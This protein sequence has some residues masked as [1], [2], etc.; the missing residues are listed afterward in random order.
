M[1]RTWKWVLGVAAALIVA[2]VLVVVI[3]TA[4]FLGAGGSVDAEIARIKAEG[5]PTTAADL[6]GKPIPDSENAA[7]TYQKALKLLPRPS[8]ERDSKTLDRFLDPKERSSDPPLWA[9]AKEIVQRYSGALPIAREAATKPKCRFAV[10]WRDPLNAEFPHYRRLRFLTRLAG[11]KAVLEARAGDS[12]GA[13]ES[14]ELAYGMNAALRDEPGLIAVLVRYAMIRCASQSLA[15]TARYGAIDGADAIRLARALSQIQ[16][17]GSMAKAYQGERAEGIV[18]FGQQRSGWGSDA[19]SA[20]VR[21]FYNAFPGSLWLDSDEAYYLGEMAR[22]IKGANLPYRVMKPHFR[23]VDPPRYALISGIL[24]S[25]HL[26]ATAARDRAIASL[27]GDQLFLGLV[28]YRDRFGSYPAS[29]A[30]LKK[31]NWQL[32]EDPFSGKPFVYHRKGSGFVL[33]SIGDDLKD[34]GGVEPNGNKPG[35]IVWKLDR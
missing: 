3:L 16:L 2:G 33:Y 26:R 17:M 6:A 4:R 34:N 20:R 11:T 30:D 15:D 8:D 5:G 31:V 1:S 7:V 35:D 14:V 24:I 32:P 25:T 28:A 23:A 19:D 21:G 18:I 9:Q 13:I 22:Q 29:L 12:E 27:A 10:D